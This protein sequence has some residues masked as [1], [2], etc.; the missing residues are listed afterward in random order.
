MKKVIIVG[1]GPA[2]LFCAHMLLKH[3]FKVELYEKMSGVGKKFLIAGK[4]GLNLTH[5]ENQNEF[6]KKYEKDELFFSSL[7]KDFSPNNLRDWA[8][9]IGIE[10]FVGS[11]GRVFPTMM[12]AAKMLSNWLFEL[13]SYEH[14]KLYLNH[15]LIKFD[16]KSLTFLNNEKVKICDYDFAVMAMGGASWKK[17][18]SDGEWLKSFEDNH[19][20]II[21]F[22]PMN[23][24]LNI[25]WSDSFLQNFERSPL[26]NV[27]VCC[28]DKSIRSEVL[29][30]PYG[31]EGTA[32]YTL[33]IPIR[34]TIIKN[35]KC[36]IKI[37]LRPDLSLEVIN[38]KLSD[39]KNKDSISN[40]LRK[41]L[42]LDK[43]S[44]KLIREV[45]SKDEWNDLSLIAKKIKNLPLVITSMRPIDEAISTSGG[46]DFNELSSALELKKVPRIFVA[47]EMLDFDAP[48][49]GYLLQGC[50]ST[51]YRV[52]CSIIEQ[53]S[54]LDNH[55]K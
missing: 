48:T 31:I 51:A 44:I 26:K 9:S 19:I 43:I 1:A 2:G 5:G 49:G 53:A 36:I 47:G 40:H 17:T 13:K 16:N 28:E 18:G 20:N 22:L 52:A 37:D 10:T 42:K 45:C 21:P 6:I 11:S 25:E 41:K 12:K 33:S 35:G 4:S 24:G 32:I 38:E 14:F 27:L 54:L 30:T 23:C 50:F 55:H 46:V 3:G 15:K 34:N 7:I 39:R 8:Q 29:L